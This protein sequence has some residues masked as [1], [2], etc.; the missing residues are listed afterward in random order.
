VKQTEHTKND[1]HSKHF[2]TNENN[3]NDDIKNI[4][5]LEADKM[6]IEHVFFSVQAQQ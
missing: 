5:E 1:E 2:N 4:E 6:Q 3:L